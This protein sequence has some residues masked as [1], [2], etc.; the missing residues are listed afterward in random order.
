M[1]LV[2]DCDCVVVN[3][4]GWSPLPFL[5]TKKYPDFGKKCPDCV[6]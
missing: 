3:S 5:K 4:R 2:C 6:H 1:D